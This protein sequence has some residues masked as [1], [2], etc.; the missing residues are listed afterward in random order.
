VPRLALYLT[1]ECTLELTQMPL[2]KH[3]FLEEEKAIRGLVTKLK[4]IFKVH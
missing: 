2:D 4:D 1:S 3:N